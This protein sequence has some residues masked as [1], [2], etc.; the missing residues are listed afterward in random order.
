L[1]NL[2]KQIFRATLG[3][4]ENGETAV[5]CEYEFHASEPGWHCHARC[6]DLELLDS[7]VTRFGSKRLPSAG[8]HHRRDRFT[9]GKAELTE[10]TAF[11]A[12]VKFFKLYKE[13]GTL[14]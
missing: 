6:D 1:L 12:A 11:N 14:K 2:S 10:V 7:A 8:K 13:E 4:T 9:F 3:V 5:L